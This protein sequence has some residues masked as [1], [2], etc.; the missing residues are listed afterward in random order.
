M[1][2]VLT[3]A[4]VL[5]SLI[6]KAQTDTSGFAN[7]FV[8]MFK[9]QVVNV[10][11]KDPYSFQLLSINYVPVTKELDIKTAITTDSIKMAVYTKYPS[12]RTKSSKAEFEKDSQSYN[13]NTAKLN[14]LSEDEK[15]KVVFYQ[16]NIECRGANSYGN[17]VYNKYFA[18][19]DLETATLWKYG[20]VSTK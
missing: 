19:Y 8:D 14:A 4:F 12:L 11:F 18:R 10:S 9:T 15:S 7:K 2:K 20:F 6:S 1:K 5:I 3:L 17:L 16:V 13:D